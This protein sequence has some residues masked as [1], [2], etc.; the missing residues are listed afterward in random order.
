MNPVGSLTFIDRLQPRTTLTSGETRTREWATSL[1]AEG[2][3]VLT[4]NVG[5][6]DSSQKE[7]DLVT[8]LRLPLSL[9][10]AGSRVQFNFDYT[11][12]ALIYARNSDG[13][14]VL[15]R[16]NALLAGEVVDNFFYLEAAA[17]VDQT[18]ISPFAPRPQTDINLTGNRT[19][20]NTLRLSPYI[21]S[22]TGGGWEYLLR[23]DTYWNSYS[24]SQLDSSVVD[25]VTVGL[26]APPRRVRTEL[27]YTYLYTQYESQTDGS[28]Q[29]VG[30]ARP[31]LAVTPRLKLGARI[32]Y[33]TNDYQ[34]SSY[35]GAVYGGELEWA[36]TPRT[37]LKGFLEHRFFGDSYAVDFSHRS[38]RTIWKLG[39]LRDSYTSM[40]QSLT[41]RPG[42]TA[43]V[44][45]DSLRAKIPDPAE[46]AR[47]VQQLL[48]AAGLPQTLTQPY[49][50]YANQI[51]LAEQWSGS[52]AFV[53]RRNSVELA[54]FWQQDKP[55]TAGGVE[56]PILI[57]S[58]ERLRQ[59]GG[60]LTLSHKLTPF[61]SLTLTA[62]RL[63][64]TSDTGVGQSSLESIE[65]AVRI[66]LSRR[67][68]PRTT[69]GVGYRWM[70]SD[71]DTTP[72]TENALFAT[73]AHTF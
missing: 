23:N 48:T 38:R 51:Y 20:Q 19:Q 10:R 56:L 25:R 66:T 29:Q 18:Y 55:I 40:D 24:D 72:Y 41:L 11:P 47:A 71:S 30:R 39:A 7:S 1:K 46:R 27:D 12:T 35:S 43:Q 58:S 28:Y 3:L 73:L 63:Y 36:P 62:S 26:R 5:L 4:D 34:L 70:N 68:T 42:G 64:S 44:L 32:G 49:T 50:F 6:Q 33:E 15:H 61:S 53:G 65:D 67:L 59:Q 45:D 57:G 13:N 37:G 14:D 8:E 16:L 17:Y 60:R 52:V 21:S 54:I 2:A 31:I 9:R 69:G 22:R